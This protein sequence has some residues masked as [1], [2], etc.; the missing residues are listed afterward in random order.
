MYMSGFE[1]N[2]AACCNALDCLDVLAGEIVCEL[3]ERS[4]YPPQDDRIYTSGIYDIEGGD[5]FHGYAEYFWEEYGYEIYDD[6]EI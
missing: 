6:V 2:G 4:F 1:Y 3:D 5:C